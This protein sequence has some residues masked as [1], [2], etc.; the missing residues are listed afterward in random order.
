MF[1]LLFALLFPHFHIIILI[2]QPDREFIIRN[3]TYEQ[4]NLFENLSKLFK[5]ERIPHTGSILS[6]QFELLRPKEAQ[7]YNTNV[8]YSQ[9]ISIWTVAEALVR[10]LLLASQV[11]ASFKSARPSFGRRIS[12]RL[13]SSIDLTV[14]LARTLFFL[15]HTICGGGLAVN[16]NA[17]TYS[18]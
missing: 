9:F 7:N 2:K 17:H 13:A 5:L 6:A 10:L 1:Q 3:K 11:S 18:A 14:L 8:P 15:S 16:K 4:D 12:K